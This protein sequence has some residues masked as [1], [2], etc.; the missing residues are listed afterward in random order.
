MVAEEER[1][2]VGARVSKEIGR[3]ARKVKKLVRKCSECK[4]RD[5]DRP[6]AAFGGS[7]VYFCK[8]CWWRQS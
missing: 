5:A 2:S 6:F 4:T 1:R 7:L 3:A 8:Q